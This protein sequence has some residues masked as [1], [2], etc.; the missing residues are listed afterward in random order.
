M[1]TNPDLLFRHAFLFGVSIASLGLIAPHETIAQEIAAPSVEIS[2]FRVPTLISETTQGVSLITRQEIVARN[3]ASTAELIRDLP[4]IYVD[5][6][7]SPGGVSNV[8]IRGSDPEQVLVLIDGVRANDPT[9]SRGGSY[10]LSSV[11]PSDLERIEVI[12]GAGSAIYGADGMGGVINIVT[13]RGAVGGVKVG[14]AGEGGSRG[15]GRIQASVSG[16]SE[17]VQAS[18]NTSKL[19]DGRKSEGG[20]LDLATFNASLGLRISETGNITVFA[21]H[22][23]RDSDAFPDQSGGVRLAVL[24]TL[25]TRD[26]RESSYGANLSLHPTEKTTLRILLSR[27]ERTEDTNSPGVDPFFNVPPTVSSTDFTRDS[28]VASVLVRLPSDSDLTF[29]VEHIKE[30]GKTRSTRDL[31]AIGFGIVRGDFDLVRETDSLF[32][33]FKVK[34]VDNLTLQ[35]GIRHDSPTKLNAETSPSAGARYDFQ[36]GTTLK[37]HYSEGFRAPSFFALG[38]S[39][40]NPALVSETSRGY[41][42]GVEQSLLGDKAR[43]GLT[44]FSTRYKNLIDFDTDPSVFKLVNRGKVDS[45]GA[46]LDMTLRAVGGLMLGLNYT[47]VDT[48]ILDSTDKLRNRPRHRATLTARYAPNDAW[49]FSW[50]TLF[51]GEF[52]DSSI[53][54]GDIKMDS[55]TRTDISAAYRCKHLTATVAIDNVFGEK[56]E[57]FV[58]FAHPGAR[59]RAGLSASF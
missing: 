51:V 7:G 16:G 40:G 25:E 5:Q 21:R 19:Q 46:E 59:I 28:I 14:L 9:V 50:N 26:A 49:Q 10:D 44:W 20:T 4:G 54:T 22:N 56:Y 12:R 45:E 15:Y 18:L 34:P 38:D 41:E 8:Y 1:I 31:T 29:G 52:F 48:Q 39:F 43:I 23:E 37:A 32:G 17:Q 57:Q 24:R 30:K 27:Y 36:S 55:Y 42:A 53:P 13:R 2:A 6:V 11:D 58:G 47:Y 33:E 35:L 3:P